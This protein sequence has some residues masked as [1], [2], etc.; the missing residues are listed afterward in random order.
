MFV[1]VLFLFFFFLIP[2]YFYFFFFVFF[3]LGLHL[4]PMEIPR[5]EVESELQPP[6]V[7]DPSCICD[8]HHSSQQCQILNPLRETRA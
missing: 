1:T 2:V 6:A 8:L 4:R 3:G 5:L 7:Q